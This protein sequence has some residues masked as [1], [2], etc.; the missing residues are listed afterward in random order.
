MYIVKIVLIL[1]IYIHF[2]KITNAL[3]ISITPYSANMLLN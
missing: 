3:E 2:T 1:I